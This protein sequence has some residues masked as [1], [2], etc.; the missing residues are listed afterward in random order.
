MDGGIRRGSDVIKALALGAKAVGIGRPTLYALAGY[1]Q[2]GVEH[3]FQV[4]L[5]LGFVQVVGVGW[6][7]C[8]EGSLSP[9]QILEDEMVMNM[10]LI[11]APTVKHLTRDM[12]C[13]KSVGQHHA[14]PQDHLST[15]VYEPL[16]TQSKL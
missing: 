16:R 6:V 7:P 3:V 12:V 11:G 13:L 8:R 14:P 9:V 15:Y 4:P 1:G 10:R 2:E 5:A